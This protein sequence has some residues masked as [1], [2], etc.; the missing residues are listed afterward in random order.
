MQ[1]LGRALTAWAKMEES[2]VVIVMH[3]LRVHPEKAGL[4]M[5]SI[6]NFNTWLFII[7]D[8]FEMDKTLGHFRS[9]FGKISE[10]IR[11]VKDRRD[12][13]AHYSIRMDSVRRP[14]H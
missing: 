6:I 9:K 12:Q 11:R 3:L 4:L 2:L 7:N 13:I 5:Y 8:L 1:L 14:A 10:R